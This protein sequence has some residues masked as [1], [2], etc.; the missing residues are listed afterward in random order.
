MALWA[1]QNVQS[2]AVTAGKSVRQEQVNTQ[3]LDVV[4]ARNQGACYCANFPNYGRNG[5]CGC[6]ITK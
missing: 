1:Y 3:T 5:G 2:A 4:V 6:N